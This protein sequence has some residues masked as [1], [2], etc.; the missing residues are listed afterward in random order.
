MTCGE[1]F[2][3]IGGIGLGL[4]RA[5][6]TVRW[7][8]EKDDYCRRVLAKHWPDVAR[9][10]DVCDVGRANLEPVELIAGGFP[11]TDLSHVGRRAGIEGE[12]SGLW[13]EFCRIV[14]ELRPSY[15][16][17]ENVPSILV[18][19]MG[20]VLG[21]LAAIGYDAEWDCLPA[22][23]FG[24]PH[25]RA[26]IF[27]LAYP[28]G[29]R[30]GT[31]EETVFAGRPLPELHGGWRREPTVGRVD[32]GAPLRVERLAAIGRAVVPQVSEY[33]GRRILS[34]AVEK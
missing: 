30:Y 6:M 23:A 11:C 5:G 27:I 28:R 2:A 9:Y 25:L 34:A 19:G 24:A 17:V 32:H 13:T 33:I 12:S 26:R 1:L 29:G 15:V 4:E 7:Q 16:L 22:A 18:R 8:V 3:G 21:D 31:Q 20:R 14:G 10:E